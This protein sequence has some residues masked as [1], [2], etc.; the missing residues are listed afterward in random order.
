[1]ADSESYYS[2]EHDDYDE[3]DKS[4]DDQKEEKEPA[5]PA[6]M[7]EWI[8]RGG[9]MANSEFRIEILCLHFSES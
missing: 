5:K 4:Q 6:G 2:D 3:H 1:M 9:A 8:L 7:M